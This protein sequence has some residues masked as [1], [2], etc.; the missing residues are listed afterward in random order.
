[1]AKARIKKQY[2]QTTVAFG[3]SGLPL[4]MRPQHEIDQLAIIA[5]NSKDRRLLDLFEET[6][7]ESEL[8]KSKV[9][10]EL[11][12]VRSQVTAVANDKEDKKAK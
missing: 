10:K 1:M 7:S 11:Q 8:K 4:G 12:T 9:E 2:L 6:P 5:L 3:S